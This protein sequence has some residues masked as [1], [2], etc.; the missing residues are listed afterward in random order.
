MRK[1]AVLAA[2]VIVA[3]TSCKGAD[4]VRASAFGFNATN[5]TAAL[6][7][8][9]DSGA[10]TV[11]VDVGRGDWLLK[12]APAAA[13]VPLWNYSQTIDLCLL[14]VPLV[15]FLIRLTRAET[16]RERRWSALAI[17]FF[18]A[19]LAHAVWNLV[20]LSG[21]FFRPEGLGGLF[22]GGLAIAYLGWLAIL[23]LLARERPD[24]S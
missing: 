21:R 4:T 23:L 18:S 7:A 10:R 11:V 14:L 16:R 17:L 20:V 22:V 6:Q 15:Y 1:T 3:F 2:I 8:A 24:H 19:G 13:I 5:A 12:L 9:I